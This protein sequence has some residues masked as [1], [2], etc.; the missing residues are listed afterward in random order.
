M[1]ALDDLL[2][3]PVEIVHHGIDRTAMR[4]LQR[5]GHAGNAANGQF[6][7]SSLVWSLIGAVVLSAIVN[8]VTRGRTR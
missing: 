7:M 4:G 5:H 1:R 6:D 8:L 2:H 3:A